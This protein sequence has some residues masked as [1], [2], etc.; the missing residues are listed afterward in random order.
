MSLGLFLK[1]LGLCL[2]VVCVCY[3][4]WRINKLL[5][6]NRN[7]MVL[8]AQII[9]L[10]M[11]VFYLIAL[12]NGLYAS[13]NSFISVF[14]VTLALLWIFYIYV[15]LY[16]LLTHFFSVVSKKF[17]LIPARGIIVFGLVL[18]LGL[19]VY[20]FFQT[21]KFIVKEYVIP[22]PGLTSEVKIFHF[23]DLNLGAFRGEAFL[24]KVLE[25]VE[26]RNP[27][28]VIYNGDI[29]NSNIAL[30]EE[31]FDMFQEVQA[32]QYF[33]TGNHEFDIDTDRLISLLNRAG[34]TFLRSSMVET[35]DIQLIGL[36][37][38]NGDP[39]DLY[40][41][42]ARMMKE[43]TIEE[44]LPTI[45]RN[46]ELPTILIHHSPIGLRHVA[47]GG[48]DV[49]LSGNNHSGQK[50][51]VT[52]IFRLSFPRYKGLLEVGHTIVL[53]SQGG[54]SYASWL[55]LSTSYEFEFVTLIPG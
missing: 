35:K 42:G 41:P 13:Q 53:V 55:R 2:V 51:P 54:G 27:D 33:T 19:T 11:I 29:A 26:S 50:S 31:L 3:V 10:C 46:R 44:T 21:Q 6:A 18:C 32:E 16:L 8:I 37:Y 28:I 38:M 47:M 7:R 39:S 30:K 49:M 20:Q 1:I 17:L 40:D 43:L 45:K 15:F 24:A 52:S 34:I 12:E 14:Y 22:V 48:I 9:G 5:G 36:E 4:P 23:V 25:E